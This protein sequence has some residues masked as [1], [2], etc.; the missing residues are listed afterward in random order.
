MGSRVCVAAA[1]L[2]LAGQSACTPFVR[3]SLS[4]VGTSSERTE[5][6]GDGG[7]VGACVQL[8]SSAECLVDYP[9]PQSLAEIAPAIEKEISGQLIDQ[10]LYR[11]DDCTEAAREIMCAQ[12][13]PQ[14]VQ[15]EGEVQFS[16]LDCEQRLR[17]VCDPAV[18]NVLL[19]T[20]NFCDLPNVTRPVGDCQSL[21]ELEGEEEAGQ[22]LQHCRQNMQRMVTPWMYDLMLYYDR[23]F[24]LIVEDLRSVAPE[25]CIERQAEF[26]CQLLGQCSE[27]GE[28][29]EILNTFEACEEFVTW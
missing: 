20:R 16:S 28:R 17:A 7:L 3:R 11:S 18:V 15:E 10:A 6:G 5:G 24:T 4:P 14:C 13:F 29:I 25:V 21:E 23:R 12:R 27:D 19:G 1:L 9:I 2:L 22:G 8:E 26:M